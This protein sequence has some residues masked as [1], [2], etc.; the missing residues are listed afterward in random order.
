[1]IALLL[2]LADLTASHHRIRLLSAELATVQRDLAN[3]RA[4]L[5]RALDECAERDKALARAVTERTGSRRYLTNAQNCALI[6]LLATATD[7]G[8]ALAERDELSIEFMPEV[9]PGRGHDIRVWWCDSERVLAAQ[10]D[11]HG[12]GHVAM[13]DVTWVCNGAD[14]DSACPVCHPAGELAS[15]DVVLLGSEDQAGEVAD[16]G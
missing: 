7:H 10:F 12:R 6:D 1:M 9:S 11:V 15:V 16:R 2:R 13:G 5:S 14:E 3:A 8:L 4:Q